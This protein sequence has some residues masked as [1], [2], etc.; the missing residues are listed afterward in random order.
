MLPDAEQIRAQ[1]RDIYDTYF[2]EG[3]GAAFMKFMAVAG[4]EMPEPD[5]ASPPLEPPSEQERA[6]N[7]RFFAHSLLPVTGYHPDIAALKAA[8]TRVVVA[9]GETPNLARRAA[10][11]LAD[12]LGSP[13][14]EFPGDHAGFADP[15]MGGEPE[16]FA[17]VLRQ[18]LKADSP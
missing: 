1:E 12:A 4:L 14:A 9:G 17:R 10:Q 7:E 8:P 15:S 6:E 18:I 5:P 13:L 16:A 3:A 2:A 11:A